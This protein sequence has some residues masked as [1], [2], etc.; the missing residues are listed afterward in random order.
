MKNILPWD[1]KRGR[2]QTQGKYVRERSVELYH[3][4]RW[5]KLSK[6]FRA[7]HPL[8]VM[9]ADKGVIKPAQVTDH[10]IPYPVCG[11]DGFYDEN[12]LQALCEECNHKKGQ[13]DKAVISQWRRENARR[14]G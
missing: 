6:A 7:S 9:C 2:E 13:S 12:N 5:T 1:S 4:A 3:T 14:E 8:C 11:V 10:V